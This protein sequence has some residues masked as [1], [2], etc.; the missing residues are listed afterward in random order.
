MPIRKFKPIK[1]TEHFYQLGTPFFPVY[2]SLG[3]DAMLL[4]GG[5]GAT[6]AIMLEQLNELQIEP[7]RINILSLH[8]STTIILELSRI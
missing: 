7:E 6:V 4:E 3:K 1:I 8:M 5:T 2:L